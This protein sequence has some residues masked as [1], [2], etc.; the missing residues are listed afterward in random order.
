M[1]S[2]AVN[3]V[4]DVLAIQQLLNGIA[5]SGGGPQP[6]LVVDGLCGKKTQSAIQQFE[7]KQFGW[8]LADGRV[9]PGGQTLACMNQLSTSL[10][11]VEEDDEALRC[12]PA[13]GVAGGMTAMFSRGFTH[14]LAAA[15]ATATAP[16]ASPR[17]QS[18]L[19]RTLFVDEIILLCLR[20]H[21]RFELF[22]RDLFEILSEHGLVIAHKSIL[23]CVICYAG[24]CEK[25]WRRFERAV[26]GI[27]RAD[28]LA[29]PSR[30]FE[31][32]G[33]VEGTASLRTRRRHDNNS[34]ERMR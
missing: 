16:G 23:R 31:A 9:D 4:P 7:L 21:F 13:P 3:L 24:T 2:K 30:S 8:K 18:A 5:Y 26:G 19:L 29:K 15:A 1:D 12:H 33:R 32:S 11:P 22:Y 20:W 34:W 25:R 14:N 27:G 10:E 17:T 28:D 6:N